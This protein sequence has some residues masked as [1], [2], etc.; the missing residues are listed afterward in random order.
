LRH[1]WLDSADRACCEQFSAGR[2]FPISCDAHPGIGF[3][4]GLL[5]SS[6]GPELI[7]MRERAGQL[8]GTF[9]FNTAPGPGATI[10]V[11]VPF[12]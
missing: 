3:D 12:R 8:N 4:P 1:G 2:G 11:V 5:T 9:E 7:T 6:G 10:K